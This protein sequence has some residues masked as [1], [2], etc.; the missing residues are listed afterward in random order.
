MSDELIAFFKSVVK[1]NLLALKFFLINSS[2]PGSYIGEM[3]EFNLLILDTSLS[4]Q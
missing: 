2:K 4:T 3:P 1:N